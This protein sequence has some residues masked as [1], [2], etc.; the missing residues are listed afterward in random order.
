MSELG[1][2]PVPPG[3]WPPGARPPRLRPYAEGDLEAVYDV[4][5]RTGD[6][7]GDATGQSIYPRLLGDIYAGPYLF[8]EPGLAFV[9]DDGRRPVGYV[10]GTADT[11]AFVRAYRERWM[12]HLAAAYPEPPAVPSTPDE[13]LLETFH[14]PEHMVHPGLAGYPAH[15]HIDILPAF[16]GH[17]AGRQLI[18]EFCRAAAAAGAAA[19]HVSVAPSNA[20]AHRF[21][22][23]VGFEPLAVA[24]PQPTV[25]FGRP[26]AR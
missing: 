2:V 24:D 22:F 3:P 6:A 21:Y 17:G 25:F 11:A 12:P 8:L 1:G 20:G 9:L 18:E 7:G 4:C 26:T 23:A 16:Q 10:L 15:L 14:R 5:V 13:K 19:V